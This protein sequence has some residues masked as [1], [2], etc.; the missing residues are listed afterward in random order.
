MIKMRLEDDS[1]INSLES[2]LEKVKAHREAVLGAIVIGSALTAVAAIY[3]QPV[4]Q[5]NTP[6]RVQVKDIDF[7]EEKIEYKLTRSAGKSVDELT[8]KKPRHANRSEEVVKCYDG[9]AKAEEVIQ[10]R[11][12]QVDLIVLESQNSIEEIN[13]RFNFFAN[14]VWCDR[15]NELLTKKRNEYGL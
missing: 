9:K 12:G 7:F 10:P 6:S 11:D 14:Q 13:C 3:H 15:C 1:Q 8:Y 2:F 5:V 4:V